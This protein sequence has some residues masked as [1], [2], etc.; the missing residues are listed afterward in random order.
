MTFRLMLCF[1]FAGTFTG[2][3]IRLISKIRREHGQGAVQ[4]SGCG[5]FVLADDLSD[6]ADISQIDLSSIGS[7]EGR[8]CTKPACF[9][10]GPFRQQNLSD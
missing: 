5:R 1:Y 3:F 10:G 9:F 6:I 4:L 8:C 7:L 2:E